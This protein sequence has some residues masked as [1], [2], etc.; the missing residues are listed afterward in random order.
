MVSYP[1]LSHNSIV[2][3][4]RGNGTSSDHLGGYLFCTFWFLGILA[5][6]NKARNQ[7]F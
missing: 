4:I 6:V 5:L 1:F 7:R 3:N 2:S